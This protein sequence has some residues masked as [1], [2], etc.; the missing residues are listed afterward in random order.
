MV[1]NNLE[2]IVR[3]LRDVRRSITVDSFYKWVASALPPIVYRTLNH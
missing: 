2:A 3:G 1:F